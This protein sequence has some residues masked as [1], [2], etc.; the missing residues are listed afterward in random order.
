[1]HNNFKYALR[2]LTQA[3]SRNILH[4]EQQLEPQTRTKKTP[5]ERAKI[6]ARRKQ[7]RR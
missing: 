7:S 5:I 6:K 4:L 1:M 2:G 3:R